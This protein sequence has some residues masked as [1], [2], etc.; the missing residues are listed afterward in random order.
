[1]KKLIFITFLCYSFCSTAQTQP[2]NSTKH[3]LILLDGSGSM[4]EKW[5]GTTKW[6]TAKKLIS[7]TIDSIERSDPNVEIGLR[8]FGHQSPDA[9]KDCKDSKLEV[10]IGKTNATAIKTKLKEIE[11]K[12]NTPI[13]YSLFLAAGD[14]TKQGALNSIILIT[15]G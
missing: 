6:E 3:I 5:K 1:M 8:V 2:V 15:D 10:P 12:G 9:A 13:A 4:L 7:Q 11:P 14:F